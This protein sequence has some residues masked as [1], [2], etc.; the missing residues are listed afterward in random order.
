MTSPPELPEP[1]AIIGSACRFPGGA[2]SPSK[3]WELLR[4][5]RDILTG[6]PPD[7]LN[8]NR[9]YHPKG[10]F[11]GSTDVKNKGYQLEE[12][13]RVFDA[14]FFGISPA[15]AEGMDPQQRVLLETVYEAIESAGCTLDKMRGSLTS[16]HVGVMN[17][18]YGDIQLRDTETLLQYNAT[19]TARSILSNRISYVF[20]LKGPSV[21]IDTACSSSLVALHY[22]VQG[23]RHGGCETAIAAGANL[24]FDPAIYITESKLHMLSPD[25]QSR[26]WDERADGYARGEGVA[27]L[28]LKPLSKA[29]RDG[30]SIEGIIRETAVNS[31][32]R[33]QGITMPHA[34]A[35]AA[36]IRSTY[37]RAGLD[38]VRDRCQYFECHGTGTPAGDP[39]EARA[40]T[41]AFMLHR[42]EADGAADANTSDS[43]DHPL[44]VGSIKTVLGHTEGCAGL[45]GVLKALLAIK[46]RIIPPNLLFQHLHPAVAP[47][48]RGLQIPTIPTPWPALPPGAPARASVNSFG[49]GGTN[50]HAIVE[51]YE[52]SRPEKGADTYRAPTEAETETVVDGGQ[53]PELIG[54][55]ILSAASGPSLL[56][57]VRALAQHVR[58]NPS[59]NLG[60]LG[61]LLQ[62]RRSTHSV[63]TSFSAVSRDGLLHAMGDFVKTHEKASPGNIGIRP[64]LIDPNETP[65]IL[66]VFTGQGAQWPTMGRQLLQASPLFRR[67]L[68]RCEA[69]LHALPDGPPWSLIQELAAEPSVS[70]LSEAALSQPLCTAVQLG[71]VDVLTAAGIHLDAVV[72]H[73]SGE[74]AATYAAGIITLPGA[75]QIAYY[76]GLYAKLA[77]GSHGQQGGMMAVGFSLRDAIVFCNRPEFSG[78]LDVAA[79]NAPQ[80]VTLSGDRDAIE[81]AKRYLDTQNTFARIL[82]VDTAYHSHHM[83]P[84]VEP[85]LRSLL[86]CDIQVQQPAPGRAACIWNS[87]VRGDTELLGPH[88]DLSLLK[89]PYWVSNMLNMVLF[90]Q[91]LESSFWHGGPFDMVLEIGPHP[92]LR[93]PTEQTWKAAL[94]ANTIAPYSGVLKRDSHDVEALSA[95]LASV[96]A[97]LGPSFVDFEGF[98]TAFSDKTRRPQVLK[99][100]PSYAWAHDKV[101]WRESRLSRR[102]R[103]GTD[104]PHPLLGRRTLDGDSGNEYELRWRNILKLSELPWLR[105]HEVL[106]EVLLPAAAYVSIAVEAGRVV[107]AGR[108]VRLYEVLDLELQRP[109]VVP[110]AKEGVETLLTVNIMDTTEQPYDD[111]VAVSE[112][113]LQARFTYYL[114]SDERAGTLVPVGRGRIIVHLGKASLDGLPERGPMPPNLLGVDADRVY[115]ALEKVG[116]HYGGLFKGMTQV[117]RSLG[118]ATATGIWSADELGQDYAVHPATLDVAFQTV[119]PAR[120]HPSSGQI[121][122]ALLPVRIKRVTVNPCVGFLS[123]AS[124]YVDDSAREAAVNMESFVTEESSTI[125]SVVGDVLVYDAT[126]GHMAVQVES[127]TLQA[128]SQ[129]ATPKDRQMFATTAWNTDAA[130]G[131]VAPKL[132]EARDKRVLQLA[133]AID[134]IAL[135]YMKRLLE[136]MPSSSRA[137]AQLP[138]HHQSMFDAFEVLVQTVRDSQHPLLQRE[139]LSDEP[140]VVDE[141]CSQHPGQIDL[142]LAQAVGQNLGAV[143]R[144]ELQPLE[145]MLKDDMLNRFYME[146]CGFDVMNENVV[147][148][149]RQITYK[150]PRCNI[151]EIG[152]GTGGTTWNILNAI[153]NAYESYTYTDVSPGFFEKAADKFS[154]FSHRMIFKVLDAEKPVAPQGFTEYA[155]DIVV[156]AY[157]LHVSRNLRETVEH[158]RS[159]LKPGGFLILLEVTAPQILRLNL[160]MGALPG[161]WLGADDGRRMYPGIS[162][163]DWDA[164]LLDT[165]FSGVDLV[166]HDLADEIKHCNSLMVSQAVDN[167]VLKLRDPVVSIMQTDPLPTDSLLIVGGKTLTTSKMLSELTRWFPSA[168]K[169]RLKR[170]VDVDAVDIGRLAP[171]TDVICLQELDAPLF[172]TPMSEPRLKTLQSLVLKA[173]SMLWVVTDNPKTNIM[174]G[175]SRALFQE[176]PQLHLQVLRLD[177]S[178]GGPPPSILAKTALEAFVRLRTGATHKNELDK[179]LWC[180][181]P[182]LVFSHGEMLIPR[183]MPNAAANELYNASR[184]VI[185]KPVDAN[186]IAVEFRTTAAAGNRRMLT[187]TAAPDPILVTEGTNLVEFETKY[188]LRIPGRDDGEGGDDFYLCYGFAQTTQSVIITTSRS[189]ASSLQVPE[190]DLLPISDRDD[191]PAVLLNMVHHLLARAITQLPGAE[192]SVIIVYEPNASLAA[193]VSAE[194]GRRQHGVE[195]VFVTSQSDT[196]DGWIKVHPQESVRGLRRLMPRHAKFYIDCAGL[197]GRASNTILERCLS[198]ECQ[199]RKLDAQLLQEVLAPAVTASG[200][201]SVIT[202]DLLESLYTHVTELITTSLSGA[203]NPALLPPSCP[204]F[205]A[206]DLVG[207][208]ASTTMQRQMYMTS[209]EDREGLALTVQPPDVSRC[210]HPT[211]TYLMVGMAGGLGLSI[212]Q[213]MLRSGAKHMVI[214]SRQPD[215]DAVWLEEARRGGADVRIVPTDVSDGASVAS[216]VELIRREMPPLGGVCNAAMVLCDRLFV[217]MSVDQLNNTLAPKVDGTAHLHRILAD[218]PLDFFMLLS[219]S[220]S[221]FGNPGQANYHAANLFMAGLA[222]ERRQ[223]G[224]VA[225]VIH[226]GLV[227]DVG[228]VTRQVDLD[229][230]GHLR[231]QVFLPVSETDVHHAFAEAIVAGKPDSGRPFELIM[232]LEPFTE[233]LPSERRP[234]WLT[235]PRFSHFVPPAAETQQQQTQHRNNLMGGNT[236]ANIKRQVEEADTEE[237]A[238]AVVLGAFSA[239]LESILQLAPGSVDGAKP[240][241]QLGMDSLVA[242]EIRT[243]FLHELGADVPIMKILGGDTV[244]Q[245]ST[246]AARKFLATWAKMQEETVEKDK[247]RKEEK[248]E[249]VVKQD[250]IDVDIITVPC[251]AEKSKSHSEDSSCGESVAV[252]DDGLDG[253]DGASSIT[254][255]EPSQ[256]SGDDGAATLVSQLKAVKIVDQPGYGPVLPGHPQ[257]LVREKMSP[258][259][260]RLWFAHRHA[261]DPTAYNMT[262]QYEVDGLLDVERL[263]YAI[264]MT[265]Q[266]HEALRTAFYTEPGDGEP[267]QGILTTPAYL[268]K[269]L[270]LQ[271]SHVDVGVDGD[272][273]VQREFAFFKEHVWDLERG[274]TFGVTAITLEAN[275]HILLF[276]Y[277][278]I[279]MDAAS[280]ALFL[281]DLDQ[282]YQMRSLGQPPPTCI[283]FSQKQHQLLVSHSE[284]FQS[285]VRFWKE[286]LASLPDTAPLLPVAR[287]AVRP[288]HEPTLETSYARLEVDAT[289]TSALKRTCSQD[290]GITLFHCH[291][292]ALQLLLARYLAIDDVCIGIADANRTDPAFATTV[293]FF[294]S[295]VPLRARMSDLTTT[296][297]GP[298][299]RA[300]SRKVLAAL[301]HSSVPLDVILDA[302]H[303]PRVASHPPLFQIAVNYRQGAVVDVPL[304]GHHGA[305]MVLR[306][307]QDAKNPYDLSVGIIEAG[308]GCIVEMTGQKALYDD[309][310]CE[311][312]LAAYL[313]LLRGVAENPSLPAASY[314]LHDPAKIQRALALGTGPT[315]DFGWPASLS[316]RVLDMCRLHG[317]DK[318]VIAASTQDQDSTLTYS[319][320]QARVWS[321]AAALTD[322]GVEASRVVA[323]LCE[324][325]VNSIIALLAVLHIGAVYMP[326]DVSLPAARHSAMI[327]SGQPSHILFHS[328]T[329]EL[330]AHL[331]RESHS[332]LTAVRVE[333]KAATA[334]V[335]CTAR[336]DTPAALLYTSGSTGEPKGILLSQANLV[337]HVALKTAALGLGRE[338][339]LQ[340]S[341]LGFDMSL[342]QIFSALANGGTLIVAPSEWRRD[343][344]ALTSLAARERVSMTIATPSEY[345]AWMAYGAPSL[346]SNQHWKHACLG[347]EVVTD[348]LLHEFGR[349]AL[350]ALQLTNCYGPTEITA[351]ATFQTLLSPSSSAGTGGIRGSVGRALP[352]Y[353]VYIVSPSG[354]PLPVQHVGEICIGGSGVALGYHGLPEQTAACFVPDLVDPSRKM[355]RTGDMGRL[356]EDGSLVFLGRIDGDTQI[357]LRGLRVELTE[358]E[359]AVL[360]ASDGVLS[361]VVVS[362]REEQLVAHA[363]LAPGRQEAEL[364][365]DLLSRLPLPQYMV[366]ARGV[367]VVPSLP[368]NANGKIDRRAASELPC[369]AQHLDSTP[370]AKLTLREGEL[371]L[372][373]EKVLRIPG[374]EAAHI[375]AESDFFLLGGN[376]LLLMRLQAA[377]Q[378]AMAVA[379]STRDLYQAS[380]LRQMAAQIS[381]RRECQPL[382]DQAG[383]VVD[384]DVETEVP[385]WVY[386]GPEEE[387]DE[388][389]RTLSANGEGRGVQVL[390][391]GA[392]SFLGGFILQSLCARDSVT[393]V[394]C[395][396]V[397][398]DELQNL[399]P[400][401]SEKAIV[402]TGS[403]RSPTL[404]LTEDERRTLKES[405]DVV[406]HAGATGHCLNTYSSVRIPNV[407]AT[408]FLASLAI[409]RHVPFL[410]LSASRVGLLSGKAAPLPASVARFQ[411][412]TDGS[413]GYTAS[414]W[415]SEVFLERLTEKVPSLSVQ[416]HRPCVVVGT[417]APNSDALNAIIRFSMLMRKTPSFSNAEGY[418]DFQEVTV[419]GSDI[420]AAALALA[421]DSGERGAV[422]FRH[423]SSG[424]KVPVSQF[425]QRMEETYGGVF[426][427]VPAK[428]WI[429]AATEAGIDPLITGYLEGVMERGQTMVF[430]YLGESAM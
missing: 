30:D 374:D 213:W 357:K 286:E 387:L 167:T 94:G 354:S 429:T 165:G 91:A 363:T 11:H 78:R 371:R 42:E 430:P 138:W 225:S 254:D 256:T 322:A 407:H 364:P 1:I 262:F 280:W 135:F 308:E 334:H 6:F 283:E 253:E 366:P 172:A 89:G 337:N 41:E 318:A 299:A 16:V 149:M 19:G 36:L 216:T 145:V 5:P 238:V 154:Q 48:Y 160:M 251:A 307:A 296:P 7:R 187:L 349:L 88:G 168:W 408:H 288:A 416:I 422:S 221:V 179:A 75:M 108:P 426:E 197:R 217:N 196:P 339:V 199:V 335:P 237:A 185:T 224:L 279:I 60:D 21:T 117:R 67:T 116:L 56:Q 345:S 77:G 123:E 68:E 342:I 275:K 202:K 147:S 152:A 233:P 415:A 13:S 398:A 343:P 43:T 239:K 128:V 305:K 325:S 106:G 201:A 210:F 235:N 419:V 411:P 246:H 119:F 268:F 139:W 297:F 301:A 319:E 386:E 104:T 132:D 226:I 190:S 23:L 243:W 103:I 137:T 50:A 389:G 380:T 114:C 18:D 259:Q 229:V 14:E 61:W 55:L 240:L 421:T 57:N 37:L 281:R 169:R 195:A 303:V 293:G 330:V 15:E 353:A 367:T 92:A 173:R 95:A 186:E 46:H 59:L 73:S 373:W 177:I 244:L 315:V 310:A 54:P 329:E 278:H 150:F 113:P 309:A 314:P 356:A 423:H 174:L 176:L 274:C 146:G 328:A 332:P 12:D 413:D 295:M 20:D 212:C 64:R 377:I 28:M 372:L 3:L 110:E 400:C 184:R 207:V 294:M 34:P 271:M 10:E 81:E 351:A 384:W 17:A 361:S 257:M 74:I 209:W 382:E 126:S 340:Q 403:L 383:T 273:D 317:G 365:A 102:F 115:S 35:Q 122:S 287:V 33:S 83:L 125:G 266:R 189:N 62:T 148:V 86:A 26:M 385:A 159:L 70:R 27:A 118:Y 379:V 427:E 282:A 306:A 352:N 394:H 84:C 111:H 362:L 219:S 200:S 263:R 231:S 265:C 2:D 44:Y 161:W 191:A 130:L 96:W 208:E 260:S 324:P 300:T 304:G 302:A 188:S 327:R 31:D 175:I 410:Y 245:I 347:G 316:E 223:R 331:A 134:R 80:S 290:L 158:A 156:A 393:K 144:G 120:A 49:F 412:P 284:A 252:E 390:L 341:S 136:E 247:E 222:A 428:E 181:E 369:P 85:Y 182:E 66:G 261:G 289:L 370:R 39:V 51:S 338:Q 79:S 8:L 183:V 269:H 355:Y 292:A 25:S 193:M 241:I 99:D 194:L 344:V 276:G 157:V 270:N 417:Q 166:M 404:G 424:L 98:R 214:T 76:R 65:G 396:A 198:S 376:S 141:L 358:V 69:V 388:K 143:V 368:T 348:Q 346:R 204:I 360:A 409:P 359:E 171:G 71:L 133:V 272:A 163:V 97:H 142:Q 255:M 249:K 320:C 242:V 391:T 121:T 228:Y 397:P 336:H 350:P 218:T 227:I 87:S 206:R 53:H 45:A 164:L 406:I 40:I 153:G 63:R 58:Q 29:V 211:K 285:Q 101:Y 24:I 401:T 375:T 100:L 203:G 392:T 205:T 311:T 378:E 395:I 112:R 215:V 180:W 264:D 170:A 140:A 131:L 399:P 4:Q 38:P 93:G 230:D 72:G 220:A 232:G 178:H 326:L 155:Y 105:G 82:K 277:H 405:I 323:V 250:D 402:Y 312:L 248:E 52:P 381:L 127:L 47:Y 258:A 109:V 321:T 22:A 420:A 236:G 313:R 298:V 32:G 234:F 267:M 162:V 90:S 151:L 425:R 107:A 192:P 9:F 333:T 414:K 124:D 129:D 291:L 418:F